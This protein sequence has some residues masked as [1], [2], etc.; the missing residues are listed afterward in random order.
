MKTGA[1]LLGAALAAGIGAAEAQMLP[2][3]GRA[4][5]PEPDVVQSCLGCHGPRGAGVPAGDVPRIAG[6]SQYYIAKQLR[7]YAEGTRRDPEME[8]VVRSMSP[9]D[10]A[11]VAT[12]FA[13]VDAPPVQG[14]STAAP[15]G[16]AEMG[17]QLA[18]LGSAE[19]RVPA[20][21]NCHGPGGEGEPPAIP[22]LAGQGANYLIASMTA[23]RSGVRRNDE[24]DQ[25][26]VIARALSPEA[27]VAVARYYASLSPPPPGPLDLLA[28]PAGGTEG[29]APRAASP[30][31]RA[32]AAQPAVGERRV[33]AIDRAAGDPARGRAILASGVHGCAGCHSIPGV[34]GARGVAGPPLGGLAQRGFIAGQLP[35]RPEVLVAFLLDPPSLVPSTGMPRTHLTRDEALHIT[36]YLRT[37]DR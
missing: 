13:Q 24:G 35:N 28:F 16:A 32:A 17:R 20:C 30:G 11:L 27:V 19:L 12:Y 25:M 21:N 1:L 6:M 2:P 37:L 7:S 26:A 31:V 18:T 3:S 9:E 23:W 36:A 15:A 4:P 33:P 10:I 22:Y 34:R 14:G 8:A 29:V 5:P